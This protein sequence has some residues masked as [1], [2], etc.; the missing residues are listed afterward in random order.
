MKTKTI[1]NIKGKEVKTENE[2]RV[3]KCYCCGKEIKFGH[4]F[5]DVCNTTLNRQIFEFFSEFPRNKD[6][7]LI[8]PRGEKLYQIIKYYLAAKLGQSDNKRIILKSATG[9][10]KSV[11]LDMIAFIE[12]T[13]FSNSLI[14]IGS[15]SESVS[16]MHI[17]RLREWI[18]SS[19]FK[20]YM[21]G[22]HES[23]ASKTEIKLAKLNSKI[24]SM[25]QSPKTRTG[26][27]AS[28]LLVDE[29]GRMDPQSYYACY[30]NETDVLTEKG[31]I[32]LKEI[33]ENK[34][35]IK[36][37]T[38]NWD[39]Y[40]VEYHYPLKYFKYFYN[41]ELLHQTSRNIDIRVTPSHRMWTKFQKRDKWHFQ[42]AFEL[43]SKVIYL[44]D[45]P[46][47]GNHQ[48]YIQIGN[49]K[50]KTEKWL[51]F[52]GIYLAE[53]SVDS[54]PNRYGV[55]ISATYNLDTIRKILE[56]INV[57]FK[58][59][60]KRK[61]FH[62]ND[63]SIKNFLL[64]FGNS[65]TKY[66]PQDYLNF[67]KKQLGRLFDSMYLGDGLKNV[68]K[69]YYRYTTVSERLADNV[70]ELIS[71]I[72][73]TGQVKLRSDGSAYD[74]IATDNKSEV[75]AGR[76][77]L[78]TSDYSDYVYCLEVPNNLLYVRRNGKPC[79]SGNSFLQMAAQG[80]I[81]I[82]ASTP[83]LDSIV[84]QNI[85]NMDNV[86]KI[87][88]EPDDCWWIPKKVFRE[89][90]EEYRRE[91]ISELYEQLFQ[92]KF[93]S[94]TNRVIP[95]DLLLQA[96]SK[97]EHFPQSKNLMIG[98]DFGHLVDFTAV[99]V[100]DIETGDVKFVDTFQDDWPVQFQK[101]R[102][103]YRDWN[104]IKMIADKSHVGDVILSDLRDLPIEGV[105]MHNDV[106]K[107]Q[108]IDRLIMAFLNNKINIVADDFPKLITELSN[109][110]YL[111]SERKS[112]A[113]VGRG[114]DDTVIALAMA[115]KGM[116]VTSI[117]D[118]VPTQNLWSFTRVSGGSSSDQWKISHV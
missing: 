62:F 89:K 35:N 107:K 15:I 95:D 77:N 59:S 105:S 8:R 103:L 43:N 108:V 27:H 45:F 88:L 4:I 86:I 49:L 17:E 68:R 42:R 84:M 54:R 1:T 50:I 20:R 26:W 102:K 5:C 7:I 73:L 117:S 57:N 22:T 78:K 98:I 69:G 94:L 25:P 16:K 87:P 6:G 14:V 44:R 111:D 79:W 41:G 55:D 60:E 23:T 61:R 101:I 67:S 115:L 118:S 11:I 21:E 56:G 110:V 2:S 47:E 97:G 80:G 72:G 34:L 12:L 52:F 70:H 66:I 90:E 113:A 82:L 46:W 64:K 71:K 93:R 100:L 74:V 114:H 96:I 99:V 37:A 104:P 40:Q 29:V 48:E 9:A 28:L 3:S 38:L 10:G 109:Y 81:E 92:A 85:W 58:Y 83:Y 53:G 31:W 91:G 19:I 63:K 51:D 18:S 33:V 30:D 65:R 116:D 32:P 13:H 36:I 39:N 112:M 75:V 24:I 76:K 106:L